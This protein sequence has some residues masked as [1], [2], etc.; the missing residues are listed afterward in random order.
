[1]NYFKIA[2][3]VPGPLIHR[4]IQN[5]SSE[6]NRVNINTH[7]LWINGFHICGIRSDR[8][9]DCSIIVGRDYI[10]KLIEVFKC[11]S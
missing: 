10:N 11:S 3:E 9:S 5:A 2:T 6:S 1:M 4:R 8:D 7:S